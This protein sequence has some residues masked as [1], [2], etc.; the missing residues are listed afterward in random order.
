MVQ[1]QVQRTI[2]A[3]PGTGV[4]LKLP[5]DPRG[6]WQLFLSSMQLGGTISINVIA[7][8]PSRETSKHELQQLIAGVLAAFNLSGRIE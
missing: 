5:G 1:L 6:V 3:S 7:H 2:A 4:P 8:Q